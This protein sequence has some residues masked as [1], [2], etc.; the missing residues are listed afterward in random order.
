M[1]QLIL[2]VEESYMETFLR[3]LRTLNYVQVVPTPPTKT[4]TSV[5]PKYDFSDLSGKLNWEGDAVLE[6]RRLRDEW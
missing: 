2:N 5:Q 1:Q 4:Q 6:Q 3:L